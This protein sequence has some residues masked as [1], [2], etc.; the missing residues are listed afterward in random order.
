MIRIVYD[1]KT[2]RLEQH[3]QGDSKLLLFEFNSLTM[4]LLESFHV[5]GQEFQVLDEI[6]DVISEFAD[7]HIIKTEGDKKDD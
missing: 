7:K 4:S 5:Y 1:E 3:L 2:H 6:S